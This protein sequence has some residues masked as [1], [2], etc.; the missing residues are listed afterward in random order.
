M[1]P[2][3]KVLDRKKF[4]Q[5]GGDLAIL[6]QSYDNVPTKAYVRVTLPGAKEDEE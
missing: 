5:L 1:A 6:D 3:R 2:I 4:V